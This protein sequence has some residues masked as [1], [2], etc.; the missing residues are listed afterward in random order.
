MM[1]IVGRF[2]PSPTGDL[3]L[4]SLITAVASYC[5]AKQQG[6]TWLVRMEDTDTDRCK[7]DFAD[8]ILHDLARL[9]LGWDGEIRYQTEHLAEYHQAIDLLASKNL[10]Y[11]C[12][13]SRK[14]IETFYLA[15]SLASSLTTSTPSNTLSSLPVSPYPYPRLCLHKQLTLEN[16]AVRLILPDYLMGFYDNLQGNQW[17]NPQRSDSDIVLRR[18]DGI[19]NYMLAAVADDGVQGVNQIVRG[20]DILPLTLPQKCLAEDL[21]LPA[22]QYYAHLPILVNAKGQKLSKQTL[23]EPIK[24]Y[25]ASD[26]LAVAFGLLQ[27]PVDKDTPERMLAQGMTN[28]D[29]T[30]LQGQKQIIVP[31]KISDF[32]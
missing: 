10:V 6:G 11:G 4:G 25:P 13:C 31:D 3:H 9:G 26:L 30:P 28:W 21:D 23:A 2:A 16:N 7:R 12:D 15:H 8:N 18:R 20:L 32:L 19:I 5:A 24:N 22:I 29:F 14:Q 1:S 17:Q 27:Q